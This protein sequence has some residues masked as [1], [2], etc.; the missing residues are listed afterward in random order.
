MRERAAIGADSATESA[1]CEMA[2]RQAAPK[3]MNGAALWREC[4]EPGAA[5]FTEIGRST[6]DP[7]P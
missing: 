1:L 5:G 3:S 2:R 7:V 4:N 6:V